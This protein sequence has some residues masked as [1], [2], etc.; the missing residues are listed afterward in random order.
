MAQASS[1]ACRSSS[2]RRSRSRSSQ[3]S[4]DRASMRPSR[5]STRSSACCA[6]VSD[7]GLRN[8]PSVSS[9]LRSDASVSHGSHA[10]T[11]GQR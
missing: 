1:S 10:A 6:P 9:R 11:S 7:S 5:S 8:A 4:T 3:S 2:S